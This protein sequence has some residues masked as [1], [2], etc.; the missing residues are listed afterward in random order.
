MTTRSVT[1]SSGA[2]DEVALVALAREHAARLCE[3][4]GDRYRGDPR[5]FFDELA[6]ERAVQFFPKFLRHSRG[7][8]AG[9]PFE[10]EPWQKAVVRTIFGWK[11]LGTRVRVVR[12]VFLFLPRKNGKSTFSA[13][14]ALLMLIADGE[15]GAEVYSCAADREQAAIVF[16]EAVQMVTASES[17]SRVTEIFKT[18]ITCTPLAGSY[19]VLSAVA[20]GKHGLNPSAF[21]FD[22][23]H[24]QPNRD[25]YDVMNTAV[26]ARPQPLEAYLTTAGHDRH[27][28]CWEVYDYACKVRD[29]IIDEPAFLPVL[30]AAG[31]DDDWR[32]PTTWAKA[33]PSLGSAVQLD[34]LARKAK[35]AM[36]VPAYENTFKR[37]HLNLWTE[38][39]TRWLPMDRWDAC[40][41]ALG[42]EDLRGRPCWAGLDLSSTTDLSALALVFPR[43]SGP[44]YD[45][46]MRFWVPK[47]NI[48]RRAERDGVPY[49]QWARD[50]AITPT[51]GTV[52]DYDVIR[53]EINALKE[54]FDIRE[55]AVDRWNS[56]QLQTQLMGDGF[57]VVPFGQG[58]GSMT[59]PSKELEKLVLAGDLH[60]AG[61]PVLRWMASNVAPAQDPAGNIKPD[62]ARSSERI[63]GIVAL[64]MALGRAMVREASE[65]T[66]SPWDDPNFT[67]AGP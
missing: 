29:G 13:G 22:E 16:R 7:K 62:K 25:L 45:V 51:E 12:R 55:I 49:P 15:R 57:T 14:L 43:E 28:I 47:E 66:A 50:G 17:L 9:Q 5:F 34:Y 38:Q 53:G 32:D 30:F 23:L 27:S 42:T 35:E 3:A 52:V 18:A 44:G 64:I 59:A 1:S 20:D 2:P 33:N 61:N 63:D 37:L 60:H 26:G 65:P 4:L 6:A 39:A 67:L 31:E 46:L 8:L 21:I 10:L 41:P 56:T 24:T 40:G 19:K 48:R 54:E 36:E 11:W 58:Y